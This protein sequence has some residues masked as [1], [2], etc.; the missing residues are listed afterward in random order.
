MNLF[1]QIIKVI[2]ISTSN[3]NGKIYSIFILNIINSLLDIIGLSLIAPIIMMLQGDVDDNIHFNKIKIYFSLNNQDLTSIILIIFILLFIIK[4]LFFY[5]FLKWQHITLSK[6]KANLS[7]QVI[8]N[9]IRNYDFK[10]KTVT[11]NTAISIIVNDV[12]SFF[13]LIV[14]PYITIISESVILIGS[15]AILLYFN[16][17]PTFLGLLLFILF[18]FFQYKFINKRLVNIGDLAKESNLGM[19]STVSQ[20]FNNIIDFYVY[21][22][23]HKKVSTYTK[24]LLDNDSYHIKQNL[25]SVS[26]R[27]I[28]EIIIVIIFVFFAF[29]I[30]L[31]ELSIENYL[32]ILTLYI[33][34]IFRILPSA[35]RIQSSFNSIKYGTNALRNVILYS[36]NTNLHTKKIHF[37]KNILI[38]NIKFSFSNDN[39]VLDNIS[40][41]INKGDFIGISGI[42]GGGKSTLINILLSIYKP[43]SGSYIVDSNY[44]ND[45]SNLDIGFVPQIVGIL[46]DTLINNIVF[47]RECNYE[48]SYLVKIMKLSSLNEFL[49]DLNGETHI[50]NVQCG[51][52]GNKISGGQRQRIGIARA[53]LCNPDIIILDE[54]TSSLD[55]INSKN[56][57]E[58][59]E[60]LAGKV[61]IILVT[62]NLNLLRKCTKKYTIK[63]GHLIQ[64]I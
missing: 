8:N 12:S 10:S 6:Y 31:F 16:F 32:P 43:N 3:R 37:N 11:H 60:A 49:F 53:L 7:I 2:K 54:P 41:N 9:L 42:S 33:A 48:K 44:I 40:I 29:Y 19:L 22:S 34:T 50:K 4:N 1:S 57:L 39:L 62:H 35:N 30:N 23:Y 52:M 15:L 28:F 14:S 51:F 61:T 26:P 18:S 20:V 24:F 58:T 55:I 56:I 46:D 47:D 64:H 38:N 21:N 5:N 59:I 63:E 27:I 25:L 13:T 36:S 45:L 17:L